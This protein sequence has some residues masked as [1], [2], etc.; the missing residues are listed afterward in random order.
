ME[1]QNGIS[2]NVSFS[3]AAADTLSGNDTAFVN[4][5]GPYPNTQDTQTFDWGL[6]FYYGNT[7]YTVIES[8][9][10]TVGTGPYVAF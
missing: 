1:G 10:T 8:A 4:L 3:V 7:V 9:T 2:A 6:P 5:G